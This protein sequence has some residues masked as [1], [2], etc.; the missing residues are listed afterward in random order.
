MHLSWLF[1]ML[2]CISFSSHL[3]VSLSLHSCVSLLLSN[4]T[5]DH[6]SCS[7]VT[8][9]SV[10]FA[11]L[12]HSC[13]S[14]SPLSHSC[15]SLLSYSFVVL[16]LQPCASLL[17]FCHNSVCLSCSLIPTHVYLS[18]SSHSSASLLFSYVLST[19]PI[20]SSSI[21]IWVIEFHQIYCT[22]PHI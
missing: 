2:V 1:I 22:D 18:L 8:L 12:S 3:Y 15:A 10:S 20:S 6:L 9:P 14:L 7:L 4:C 13:V 17:L 16:L 11:L 5:S 19:N 21:H